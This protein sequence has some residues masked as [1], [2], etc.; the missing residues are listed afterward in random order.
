MDEDAAGVL[1]HDG[2][3]VHEE[4]GR[5]GVLYKKL[6]AEA[7]ELKVRLSAKETDGFGDNPLLMIYSY[8]ANLIRR[9]FPP[10]YVKSMD[11][12]ELILYNVVV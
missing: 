4:H 7:T 9:N 11:W 8:R 10:E 12:A 6:I 3:R 1:L 5:E 2:G